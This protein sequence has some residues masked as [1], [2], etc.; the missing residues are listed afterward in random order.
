MK[1]KIIL[2]II[3]LLSFF[4]RIYNINYPPLLWDEA[5][6]GYNAYS[7]LK[8]GQDEYGKNF[9]LILKSFGDYKPG[10]YA[11][12]IIPF[13]S[14][15]GLN[16]L[17]VR[18]PSIILGSLIPVLIY[19][20]IT[21]FNPKKRRLAL[22]VSLIT[23]FNPYNIH[24]SRG[25]WET[26]ILTFQILLAS[27]FFI[28]NKYLLSSIIFALSLYTYQG[29]KTASF[30]SIFI[31]FIITHYQSKFPFK[32]KIKLI[33]NHFK[34]KFFQFFL[35]FI[36]ISIPLIIGLFTSSDSNRLKVLS[37]F[38]Y[39]RQEQE[40]NF[41]QNDFT[42]YLKNI[43]YRYFN[44]FSPE[45]LFSKGDWQNPRHS[46]PYTGV[47]LLPSI[48][49]LVIGLFKSSYKK[50]INLFF[51]LILLFAPLS[52][53]FTRDSIQATRS[54]WMSLGLVYF[55][56]L[57]IET[58]L[59]K[60]KNITTYF[61]LIIIYLISF[62]YYADLYLN[63]MVKTNSPDFLL[64]YK[65]SISYLDKNKDKY[66]NFI[67]TDFYGQPQIFY[68]FYTKYNPRDYQKQ[69]NLI[70][71]SPDIGK[72]KQI[73][74]IYFESPNFNQ[75]QEKQGTIAIFSFDEVIRQNLDFNLFKKFGNFYIYEN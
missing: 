44:H 51:L 30:L 28:K 4:I 41:F 46:A 65:E 9:P 49:F 16:E 72:I 13:I 37:I 18:L 14:I 31:L 52:A 58:F 39:P 60:Y 47:L 73:D 53:S 48:I 50:N 75:I 32:G 36:I 27:Y 7:I 62:I 42:F 8:T 25:A 17:S 34:Q 3:F 45:F 6:L 59:K 56:S 24:Y 55:T 26:N 57:G 19:L 54:M 69:A 74:N 64:G 10:L 70:T 66:Q 29:A 33:F 63:H 43:S 71:D 15:F 35:P 38:S 22:I 20:L 40:T 12:L 67:I 61:L 68:L 5:S 11:Y 1:T 23:I 21:S 2:I